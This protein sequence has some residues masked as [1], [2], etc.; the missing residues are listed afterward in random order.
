MKRPDKDTLIQEIVKKMHKEG[1][2]KLDIIEWL[3]DEDGYDYAEDTAK[4]ILRECADYIKDI[5][6]DTAAHTVDDQLMA[7][8]QD[9]Q[10]ALKRGDYRLA[11]DILK[12]I[13]KIAGLY[14]ERIDINHEV[15]F[16]TK[17]GGK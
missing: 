2:T 9:R 17:W 14:K 16:K 11:F 15:T 13:D 1:A 6:R 5:Y 12:E 10:A 4:K 7:L 3:T 8:N